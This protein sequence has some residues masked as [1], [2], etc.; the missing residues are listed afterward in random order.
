MKCAIL[1]NLPC[2]PQL[3]LFR[4]VLLN[5]QPIGALDVLG[6]GSSQLIVNTHLHYLIMNNIVIIISH[7]LCY[8]LIEYPFHLEMSFYAS[9][10]SRYVDFHV[11]SVNEGSDSASH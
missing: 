8:F 11:S 1:I 7:D 3:H 10:M 2:L 6:V 5:F 4:A 9:K